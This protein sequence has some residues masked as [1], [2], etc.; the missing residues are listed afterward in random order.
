MTNKWESCLIISFGS[1]KEVVFHW[2]PKFP[3]LYGQ[4]LTQSSINHYAA[5]QKH[6]KPDKEQPQIII[7]RNSLPGLQCNLCGNQQ[8]EK[9][10]QQSQEIRHFLSF[11][12]KPPVPLKSGNHPV[13][14]AVKPVEAM[15]RFIKMF[16]NPG[17][18]F[19]DAFA[20]MHTTSIAALLENRNAITIEADQSQWL[21]AQNHVKEVVNLLYV[22]EFGTSFFRQ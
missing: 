22:K 14:Y 20:G 3:S 8:G 10:T 16:S 11:A 1:P 15:C 4:V 9:Q 5:T 18:T 12:S 13:N 6:G 2:S 21:S 17:D 19:I 7:L